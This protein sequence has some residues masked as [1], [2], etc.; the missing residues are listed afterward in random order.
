MVRNGAPL[1]V[2]AEALGHSGT[3]TAEKH[4]AHR[5]PSNVADTIWRTAPNLELPTNRNLSMKAAAAWACWD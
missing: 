3:R 4:Y 2:V 5:A 1:I